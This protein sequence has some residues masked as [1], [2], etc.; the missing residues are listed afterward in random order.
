MK[1]RL[2]DIFEDTEKAVITLWHVAENDRVAGGQDLLEIAT[3][4]ATFD[5][6][7]PCNGILASIMKKEGEEITADEVIAE[8]IE[9]GS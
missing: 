3:D 6:A 9:D 5:I 1:I 7:A 2:A 4:K 8:L